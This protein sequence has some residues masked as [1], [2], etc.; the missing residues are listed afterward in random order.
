ME[1]FWPFDLIFTLEYKFEN[2]KKK[3]KF[4]DEYNHAH[5]S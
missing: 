5:K 4:R 1:W 2:I 3:A